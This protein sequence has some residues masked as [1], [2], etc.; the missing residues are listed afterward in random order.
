MFGVPIA[1][2]L[3]S[4]FIDISATRSV[5][6]YVR[7]LLRHVYCMLQSCL[8]LFPCCDVVHNLK[9]REGCAIVVA[10]CALARVAEPKMDLSLVF[11]LLV[12]AHQTSHTHAFTH[13]YLGGISFR[14][15]C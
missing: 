11:V 8:S 9:G 6:P 7:L 1:V 4:S 15:R 12:V 14:M 3:S 10:M 5:A 2:V 13:T